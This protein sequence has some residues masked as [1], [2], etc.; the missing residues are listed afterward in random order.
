MKVTKEVKT[1]FNQF[2]IK[3]LKELRVNRKSVADSYKKESANDKK[4]TIFDVTI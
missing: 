2:K 4:G 3:H 1:N